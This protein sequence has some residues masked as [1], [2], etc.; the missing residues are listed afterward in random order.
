MSVTSQ[1]WGATSQGNNSFLYTLRNE[2]LQVSVTDLGAALVSVRAPDR[3]GVVEN[4]VVGGE[5]FSTYANNSS[6]LGASVG[7]FANRIGKGQF[8]LDGKSYQLALNN[9]PNHLHG[10]EKGL[11]HRQFQSSADENSVQFSTFS[12]DGEDGYPGAVII[13]VT[14]RLEGATLSIEYAATTDAKTVINLTNHT[15]WNLAGAGS[16]LGF[17]VEINAGTVLEI[18]DNVLPTGKILE[19][20]GTPFDFR[21]PHPIGESIPQKHG[22][23]DNCFVIRDWDSTLRFAARAKDSES[24]RVMDV[25]TTVPGV[26]L[27]TANHFDGSASVGG[28]KQHEA[29]CLE[30][31]HFP[32]S[33]N[34]PQFPT[35]IL[36]PGQRYTQLTQHRFSVE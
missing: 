26:Q 13:S 32:D 7:R 8:S 25:L 5:E 9:G 35:T 22:G 23:Y 29:F 14:Y 3:N 33:P 11:T 15:Y 16:V 24:G 4:I 34:N 21:K 27:Y 28:A 17:D 10:G 2:F 36:L 20:A 12:E 18:D 31:Q 30:C 1:V 6:H 19:V